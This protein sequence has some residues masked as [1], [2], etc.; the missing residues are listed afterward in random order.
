MVIVSSRFT[1]LLHS[2]INDTEHFD[3]H[4]E[5]LTEAAIFLHENTPEPPGD[6]LAEKITLGRRLAA[7]AMDYAVNPTEETLAELAGARHVFSMTVGLLGD[8]GPVE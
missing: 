6:A 8:V 2:A 3:N 5:L 4:A 7:A 1:A